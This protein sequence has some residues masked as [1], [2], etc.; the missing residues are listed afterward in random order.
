MRKLG[1]RLRHPVHEVPIFLALGLVR[2]V[3][4]RGR[5]Y[6]YFSVYLTSLSS[7]ALF[8][9]FGVA[10]ILHFSSPPLLRFPSLFH[11]LN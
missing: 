8:E 10:T 7:V 9:T 3:T 4:E 1:N 11:D 2:A 5:E 6:I